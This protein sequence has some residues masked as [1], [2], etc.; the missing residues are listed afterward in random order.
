MGGNANQGGS[1][2][3]AGSGN[4][5]GS[6][7]SGAGGGTAVDPHFKLAWRDAFDSFV[8]TRWSKQTHTFEENDLLRRRRTNAPRRPSHPQ[9]RRRPAH[10]CLAD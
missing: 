10:E 7:T 3:D 6:G 5:A 9:R 8:V 4:A 1:G 2:G